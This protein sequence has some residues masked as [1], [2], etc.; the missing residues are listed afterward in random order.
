[1]KEG[2]QG[3][4][5]TTTAAGAASSASIRMKMN[6]G[7]WIGIDLG[8]SNSACAVWDS[9][10]GGSKWMRLPKIAPIDTNNGGAG[11]MGRIMPSIVRYVG[12]CNNNNNNDGEQR[13]DEPPSPLVGCP[14]LD[15]ASNDDCS[16]LL[17]S[18]KRLLGKHMKDLDPTWI[19]TLDYDIVGGEDGGTSTE[20]GC[21]DNNVHDSNVLRLVA[22]TSDPHQ[23]VT[24]T[25]QEVLAHQLRAL[26]V[27]SQ[28]YLDRYRLK[29]N[30]QVPGVESRSTTKD[31]HGN[32]DHNHNQHKE[33]DEE[34]HD[35]TI[36]NVIV[37]VPAHFSQRMVRLIE[38]AC[39]NAGFEGH[40]G[41]C[42]ESTAAA[43]AYGITLQEN[44]KQQQPNNNNHTIMVIDMGGGTSDITIATKKLRRTNQPQEF[45]GSTP[46][47]L[48]DPVNVDDDDETHSSSSS[49]RVLVTHGNERLGGDDID[50]LILQYCQ[51]QAHK[52]EAGE[53][54]GSEPKATATTT[55]DIQHLMLSCRKAKEALC[56]KDDPSS[57]ETITVQRGGG[58]LCMVVITQT[59][60]C[61]IIEPWLERAKTMIRHT[62]DQLNLT[63][64]SALATELSSSTTNIIGIDEVV[65]VGGTTRIPAIRQMIQGFFPTVELSTSLDPMSS[66]A[67]GLAVQAAIVSNCIPIHELRS[68]LML[69]CV[70]HSI[71]VLLSSGRNDTNGNDFGDT[72]VEIIPRNA[73]LP[74]KGTATFV[75]AN[76]RQPGV[77][78]KAVE[79]IFCDIDRHDGTNNIFGRNTRTGTLYETMRKEDFTFLLRRLTSDE[80][81][82]M[83]SRSIEI[84]M[85]VNTDGSFVVSVFD[86]N[87]PDQVR[88]KERYERI[89]T[90]QKNGNENSTPDMVVGELGYI[91][92]DLLLADSGT[93]TEQ[94]MLIMILIGVVVLYIGVRIAFTDPMA[95]GATIL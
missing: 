90:L 4:D 78:I 28:A 38:G 16:S 18:V 92:K 45:E 40:V 11:K 88:K 35:T 84:G 73:P 3:F 59:I 47:T 6:S 69:D 79:Q 82:S 26:R 55:T 15:R 63:S 37:G 95:D 17:L 67:L 77:T 53:N 61:A 7:I 1:M 24:T 93:T 29:K 13:E 46:N 32:N 71:G 94:F 62:L 52:E 27:A 57:S 70:P 49:Y 50:H 75:L 80:F 21:T 2:I 41:T 76:K 65:L 87:D 89:Q 23:T 91:V 68:A 14:A 22:R 31:L 5:S 30:L 33:V 60:F 42:L 48:D 34:E 81:S 54:N 64:A 44:P 36:R 12:S 66:V 10:R 19:Q 20:G 43:I 9:T 58:K 25:P 85:M 51:Q 72:F 39:R 56:R 83:S 8:T 86:E 74:A